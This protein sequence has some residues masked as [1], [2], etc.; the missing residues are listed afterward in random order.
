MSTSKNNIHE[1]VD[2]LLVIE[3]TTD[4]RKEEFVC[5]ARSA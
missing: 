5:L 2:D 4:R 3:H 1:I